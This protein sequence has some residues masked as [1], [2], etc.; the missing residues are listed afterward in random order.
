MEKL[1]LAFYDHLFE[2]KREAEVFSKSLTSL[3]GCKLKV[4]VAGEVIKMKK[5]KKMV[6]TLAAAENPCRAQM[7]KYRIL[8][9][10]LISLNL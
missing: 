6:K 8:Y 7:R 2:V 5:K 4:E 9:L 1:S 10:S 3:L